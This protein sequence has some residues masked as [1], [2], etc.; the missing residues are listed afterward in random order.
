MNLDELKALGALVE[1]PPVPRDV[2]WQP[3]NRET[4]EPVG[5]PRTDTV[6]VKRP[7]AGWL[8]RARTDAAR[9]TNGIEPRTAYIAHAIIFR[10]AHKGD[11]QLSY[12]DA[13]LLHDDLAEA[14][15]DAYLAVN[16]P[17]PLPEKKEEAETDFAKNSE[18]TPGSG[19]NSS[20]PASAVEA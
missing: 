1:T 12:D 10:D 19:T 2:T 8:S 14:L 11:Q 5:E 13:Y 15:Y 9:S 6:Y 3:R 16:A 17:P 18:P 7:S 4:G 20:E